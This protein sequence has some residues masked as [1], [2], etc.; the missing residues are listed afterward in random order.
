MPTEVGAFYAKTHFSQL[1]QRV[2][3]GEEFIVTKRGKQVA[4]LS[5][6]TT[7]DANLARK[8]AY[9]NLLKLRQEHPIKATLA[10]IIEWKNEGRP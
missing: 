5:P 7:A 9:N 8:E 6:A 2:A 4:N 10:E 1:L 3:A